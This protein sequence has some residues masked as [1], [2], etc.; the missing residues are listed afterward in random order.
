MEFSFSAAQ[1]IAN[2]V[3]AVSRLISVK[4]VKMFGSKSVLISDRIRFI[5]NKKACN[6]AGLFELTK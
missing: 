6:D 3:P 4:R 5:P 1:Y 2:D